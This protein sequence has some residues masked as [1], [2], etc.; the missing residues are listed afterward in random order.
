MNRT[1][2]SASQL[3]LFSPVLLRVAGLSIDVL[4]VLR[5]PVLTFRLDQYAHR[6]LQLI[7]RK[8]PLLADLFAVIEGVCPPG[9]P[10]QQLQQIRRDLHNDRPVR[11]KDMVQAQQWLPAAVL[12]QLMAY[13]DDRQ[14]I[15]RYMST[16]AKLYQQQ[17]MLGR[18]RFQETTGDASFQRGLALSSLSLLRQL[19][20][21]QQT[22]PVAF[23]KDD[24]QV[25]HGLLRY[26][27]RAATK[28]T[29][30]STLTHLATMPVH[31]GRNDVWKAGQSRSHVRLSV[32]L[33]GVFDALLRGNQR[34]GERWLVTLNPAALVSDGYLSYVRQTNGQVACVRLPVNPA[35]RWVM[36]MRNT[37]QTYKEWVDRI[38]QRF[39]TPGTEARQYIDK[40]IELGL[41]H[42][43]LP[44]SAADAD[45][46]VRLHDWLITHRWLAPK[47]VDNQ[48]GLLDALFTTARMLPMA[49]PAQR[50]HLLPKVHGLLAERIGTLKQPPTTDF[51]P[52]RPEQLFFEDVTRPLHGNLPTPDTMPLVETTNRLVNHLASASIA[53]VSSLVDLFKETF[54]PAEHVSLT[55][56][57][58]HY[59]SRPNAISQAVTVLPA[60]RQQWEQWAAEGRRQQTIHLRSKQIPDEPTRVMSQG[61]FWQSWIDNKGRLCAVLNELAGGFGRMY[62]RFLPY[63][64]QSLTNEL[65]KAN[66]S[67]SSSDCLLVEATDDHYH[68]AN[69]HPALLD[70]VIL[71]PEAHVPSSS[72]RAIP[73]S[74]LSVRLSDDHQRLDL[75]HLPTRKRVQVGDLGFQ[76]DRSRLYSFL[77]LF[78]P[79]HDLSLNLFRSVINQWYEAQQPA[80][81]VRIWP[82]IVLDQRLIVQRQTWWL[83]VG[84][85]ASLPTEGDAFTFFRATHNWRH[86]HQLPDEVFVSLPAAPNTDD[87]KPQYIRFD[88]VLLV[89]LFRR[90]VRKAVAAGCLLKVVEMRPASD[91]LHRIDG[92]RYAVESVLQWYTTESTRQPPEKHTMSADMRASAIP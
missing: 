4:D 43:G 3:K 9:K 27:S 64:G 12:R 59:L 55:T 47:F 13:I 8:E 37:T 36:S 56:F 92:Q 80:G 2:S 7:R 81:T 17:A 52:L 70:G 58:G 29:P 68:N 45:W 22:N 31:A 51:W 50:L 84:A 30:Y 21:Y 25:E 71:T 78:A 38:Q 67:V 69:F 18:K 88:N 35:L 79:V 16:T 65:I 76:A 28:T 74:E 91:V 23:R 57:F 41:L 87:C 48:L 54:S 5:T 26:L 61:V 62:G 73:I 63:F 6:R 90:L 83:P 10:Q 33:L 34:L 42:H 11:A 75:W 49:T 20:A 44:V 15:E 86:T 53:P 32:R 85:D 82:R 14:R 89:D 24:F 66:Q 72:E 39:K 1:K 19:N 40:L 46:A 60:V 77:R